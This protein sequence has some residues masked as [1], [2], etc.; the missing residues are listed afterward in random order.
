MSD[1]SFEG[2]TTI[3]LMGNQLAE[4]PEGL[5]CPRLKVLLLGLD[6]GM[7]VPERFFEGMKE[8]EEILLPK[9][10]NSPCSL[11]W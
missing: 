10:R 2:C 6:D 5:V 11:L 1:T 7:N 9:I 3:S 8:I 4:L